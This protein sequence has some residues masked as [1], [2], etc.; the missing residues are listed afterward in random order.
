[1]FT[2]RPQISGH[3]GLRPVILAVLLYIIV[4]VS[5]LYA[6]AQT[7]RLPEPGESP[8]TA[9]RL[10]SRDELKESARKAAQSA[11]RSLG[12]QTEDPDQLDREQE[13]ANPPSDFRLNWSSLGGLS[14]VLLWL[15][16][17]AIG[18]IIVWTLY[19]NMSKAKARRPSVG[20]AQPEE[21]SPADLRAMT[22]RMDQARLA[23]DELASQGRFTEAIHALLL[24]SITEIKRLLGISI[25]ISLTS[26][27][28]LNRLSLSPDGR[29]GLA[30]IVSRV[31]I[32]YFGHHQPG[33]QDYLDCRR[34][35]EMLTNS[36]GQ[37]GRP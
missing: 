19:K 5:P 3:P 11:R 29:S 33:Q 1:M 2:H 25:A 37:G 17:A 8:A 35:F 7:D 18:L 10:E 34:S 20:Q 24:Q 23:A 16:L 12:L 30:D 13:E 31:E 6:A 14:Q 15:A 27:E 4:G 28:I 36:L 21:Q 32:S 22:S 26:R 9:S